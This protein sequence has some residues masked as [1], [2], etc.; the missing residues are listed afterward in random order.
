M[1]KRLIL[2]LLLM[3]QPIIASPEYMP[4]EVLILTSP[5]PVSSLTTHNNDRSLGPKR[6]IEDDQRIRS[7]KRI[8][9][10]NHSIRTA[11]SK[12][13][14]LSYFSDKNL[15]RITLRPG[16]D[17]NDFIAS[18]KG[19]LLLNESIS[20]VQPNYIYTALN[21]NHNDPLSA[22][23]NNFIAL[24]HT[25]LAW[26]TTTG[27][28]STVIAIIDTG[29]TISHED[30]VSQLWTNP[31]EI[32]NGSDDDGNGYV[33]DMHGGN[34]ATKTG[35]INDDYFHGTHVAGIA[36][37]AMGNGV[38]IAGVCPGGRIMTIKANSP[39]D[40]SFTTLSLLIA[41]D[42]AIHS[43]ASVINLSLG[44]TDIEIELLLREKIREA[45]SANIPVVAA[46]GNSRENIGV[47]P[48]YPACFPNVIAVSATDGLAFDTRYSNFG[49]PV[50]ISAPGTK[51]CSTIPPGPSS[52]AFASGT[53][54]AAPV[55][56]GVVG[57]LK[58]IQPNLTV[59]EIRTI[60]SATADDLGP[61]GKD[62]WYGYGFVNANAAVSAIASDHVAPS[63]VSNNLESLGLVW[64]TNR[65][66]TLIF[67]GT[68]SNVVP[69]RL[70]LAIRTYYGATHDDHVTDTLFADETPVIV[71]RES[72]GA[73][74]TANCYRYT[75]PL[76]PSNTTGIDIS[77]EFSD[78]NNNIA[79][80]PT[81][82]ITIDDLSAPQIST[83]ARYISQQLIGQAEFTI[84]D[85]TGIS[86][87][88]IRVSYQ[89]PNQISSASFLTAPQLFTA[90]LPTL[91]IAL[92]PLGFIPSVS[93]TLNVYIA[94]T[95]GNA[96]TQSFQIG[97][98]SPPAIISSIQAND[99]VGVG[100]KLT[101]TITDATGV[102]PNSYQLLLNANGV[103]TDLTHIASITVALPIIDCVIA[104]TMLPSSGTADITFK[105]ANL[106]GE[107]TSTTTRVN[108]GGG[109]RADAISNNS[110]L[111]AYPNPV[112]PS[113]DS[114]IW[115]YSLRGSALT[116]SYSVY[117]LRYKKVATGTLSASALTPGYHEIPGVTTSNDGSVLPNGT[118][119]LII[120]LDNTDTH[121]VL[122]QKFSIIRR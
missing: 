73:L 50:F 69:P 115:A 39:G 30:L 52:Y 36:A 79:L 31:S 62:D 92:S 59:R 98:P 56:S 72:D 95:L 8:P 101:Y 55:V 6:N 103:T 45:I 48:M 114:F 113:T 74:V 83:S 53:S 93:S 34:S 71:R 10:A 89:S 11:T 97:S 109:L 63:M 90:T 65:Y 19:Q 91:S 77:G 105:I 22:T 41:I 20:I 3:I 104:E 21:V 84:A 86:M 119:I 87:D 102:S 60:L 100:S 46:A 112:N 118:Y 12:R 82:S 94:D 18:C 1:N 80:I 40:D 24:T 122:K 47:Y 27:I 5:I 99:S 7:I 117:D 116:G 111:L 108:I 15:R 66:P 76:R 23:G 29:T 70:Q 9:M 16:S 37:A 49:S 26:E 64:D 17:V 120:T 85:L 106:F 110:V 121:L 54:M 4:N 51:I 44:G 2:G 107:I 35:D 81:I 42:Y 58:S 32:V 43:N 33:D 13:P 28:P 68:D 61:P 75:M 67:Y 14:N 88:S 38:G 25:N 96:A 57:L 78:I